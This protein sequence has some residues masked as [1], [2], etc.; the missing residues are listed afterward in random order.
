MEHSGSQQL[1]NTSGGSIAPVEFDYTHIVGWFHAEK[2]Y[3]QIYDF[4]PNNGW[5]CEIGAFAGKS[6]AYFQQL[7]KVNNHKKVNHL[8]IDTFEGTKNEHEHILQSFDKPLFEVF[9]ENMEK[10]GFNLDEIFVKTGKSQEILLYEFP[11]HFFDA[12]YIDGDHSYEAVK[13][14]L[15]LAKLKVKKGGIIAGHDI[16]IPSVWRALREEFG[17]F[18]FDKYQKSFIVYNY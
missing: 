8:V 16:D 12:I 18:E 9:R 15:K 14:D 3:Q 13:M 17:K 7:C 2:I 1:C 10:C 4:I 5:F 6:T 11:H